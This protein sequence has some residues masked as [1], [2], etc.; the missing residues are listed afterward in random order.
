MK[1]NLIDEEWI[2]VPELLKREGYKQSTYYNRRKEC[3]ASP[4]AKAIV[5]DGGKTKIVYSE[6]KRFLLWRS[7]RITE[8]EQGIASVRDRR[9]V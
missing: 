8:R 2:T 5:R 9:Y 7:R 1:E 6:W 3:L 4:Y